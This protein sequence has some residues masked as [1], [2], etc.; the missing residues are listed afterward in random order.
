L[1]CAEPS[2]HQKQERFEMIIG[3]RLAACALIAGFVVAAAPA[4]EAGPDAG[5]RS[6]GVTQA[7]SYSF[8]SKRA[9]GYFA[10]QDGACA[11]TM[12]LAEAEDG[13]VAPSATRLTF[14]VKPGD[15]AQLASAEG[16]GLEV[17]CTPGAGSVEVRQTALRAALATQ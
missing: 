13:H 1:A 17:K 3:S 15:S 8:G 11:L 12:F 16:Q 14:V 4:A 7:I 2:A 9:V 6:F 10:A 5:A